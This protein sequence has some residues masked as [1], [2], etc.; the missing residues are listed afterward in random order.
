MLQAVPIPGLE[1]SS[2]IAQ[3]HVVPLCTWI[4]ATGELPIISGEKRTILTPDT[5]SSWERNSECCF[6]LVRNSFPIAFAAL[7]RQ[8]APL[9]EKSVEAVH[10][11]VHPEFRRTGVGSAVHQARL[12]K[13]FQLGFNTVL[14]R[15][16]PENAG[17]LATLSRFCPEESSVCPVEGFT[18]FEIHAKK[19]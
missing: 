7:S 2:R 6:V 18:W 11:I 16:V 17:A 10:L 1:I 5:L 14:F 13:A 15:L 19:R 4:S 12:V 3:Q 8:E 9:Q